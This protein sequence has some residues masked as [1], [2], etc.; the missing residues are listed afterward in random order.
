MSARSSRPTRS[1]CPKLFRSLG[2]V[3]LSL[4][5]PSERVEGVTLS[6]ATHVSETDVA[7]PV[8]G[9][10]RCTLFLMHARR[11]A[12]SVLTQLPAA[13]SY[14]VRVRDARTERAARVSDRQDGGVPGGAVVTER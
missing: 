1:R 3:R 9:V 8:H 7:R 2:N 10:D 6:L 11:R 4:P 14:E 5:A 13:S 12:C